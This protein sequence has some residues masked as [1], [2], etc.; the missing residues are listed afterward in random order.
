MSVIDFA[1]ARQQLNRRPLSNAP[2]CGPCSD[3]ADERQY[4]M[5]HRH[6]GDGPDV[7]LH[8]PMC[9]EEFDQ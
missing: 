7:R 6:Y 3:A 2:W 9:G 4:L 8:C 5:S 1:L